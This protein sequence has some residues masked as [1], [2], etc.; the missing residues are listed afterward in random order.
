MELHY[1]DNN[2]NFEIN[3]SVCSTRIFFIIKYLR[4]A[5]KTNYLLF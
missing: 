4:A 1:K 5:K 2:N 3:Y